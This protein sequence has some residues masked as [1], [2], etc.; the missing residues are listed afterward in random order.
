MTRIALTLCAAMLLVGCTAAA[1]LTPTPGTPAPLASA[2]PTSAGPTADACSTPSSSSAPPPGGYGTYTRPVPQGMADAT[3]TLT[4]CGDGTY[5]AGS[6][7]CCVTGRWVFAN[8][9]IT[10]TET[11]GECAGPG[12][13]SWSFAGSQLSLT[14]VNDD[15]AIRKEDFPAGRYSKGP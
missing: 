8:G 4:L 7:A 3:T 14:P 13:Y 9:R 12:T 1:T 6:P 15:C 11:H 5:S 2:Q 10:F